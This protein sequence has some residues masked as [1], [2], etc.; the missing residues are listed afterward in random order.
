MIVYLDEHISKIFKGEDELDYVLNNHYQIFPKG[1]AVNDAHIDV[2]FAKRYDDPTQVT[3]AIQNDIVKLILENVDLVEGK[4]LGDGRMAYVRLSARWDST[5]KQKTMYYPDGTSFDKTLPV[6]LFYKLPPIHAKC[7]RSGTK[8]H[9]Q[10]GLGYVSDMTFMNFGRDELIGCRQGAWFKETYIASI[11]DMENT[12]GYT[13]DDF[14]QLCANRGKGYQGGMFRFRNILTWL[15]LMYTG[16]WIV[17]PSDGYDAFDSIFV[18]C[19]GIDRLWYNDSDTFQE[20]VDNT[21]ILDGILYETA[22]DGRTPIRRVCEL[23]HNNT[24]LLGPFATSFVPGGTF[25]DIATDMFL[26][27]VQS[28]PHQAWTNYNGGNPSHV[29]ACAANPTITRTEI[30][31]YSFDPGDSPRLHSRLCFKGELIDMTKRFEE[32]KKLPYINNPNMKGHLERA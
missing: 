20:W 16:S 4:Y 26:Q 31:T 19:R 17:N 8:Q 14:H 3:G 23:P 5:D 32:Y 10:C 18:R 6:D 7:T 13:Y 28:T 12:S 9:F 29:K 15:H 2:D 30:I 24:G 21:I 1:A 27:G 25:C 11:N 22:S